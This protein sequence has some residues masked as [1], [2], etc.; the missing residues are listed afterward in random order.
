MTDIDATDGLRATFDNAEVI[1]LR[2]SGNA[3]EFRCYN[4]ADTPERAVEL[5]DACLAVMG[6]WRQ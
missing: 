2:P 6:A 4:E 5:N 3:P 1:H